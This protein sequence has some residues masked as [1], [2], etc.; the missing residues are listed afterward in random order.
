M[1]GRTCVGYS[2][3][4]AILHK[5]LEHTQIFAFLAVLGPLPHGSRRKTIYKWEK[6]AGASK[7]IK[8][9]GRTDQE[10]ERSPYVL[11]LCFSSVPPF[12]PSP[13]PLKHHFL[14]SVLPVCISYSALMNNSSSATSFLEVKTWGHHSLAVG[15]WTHCLFAQSIS[16]KIKSVK[17]HGTVPNSHKY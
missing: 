8:R 16:E 7:F 12:H 10:C 14:G 15:L 13:C 17:V 2:K 6:K 11:S 5:G 3:Y 4:R 1:Y 9:R